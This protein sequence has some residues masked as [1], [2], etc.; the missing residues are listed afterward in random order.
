MKYNKRIVIDASVARASGNKPGTSANCRKILESVRGA[1]HC[2]VF[3][4]PIKTEWKNHQSLNAST[5]RTSMAA[6][7]LICK[8]NPPPT[9]APLRAAIEQRPG[10]DAMLKDCHLLEAALHTDKIVISLDDA[11]R[12]AYAD[13]CHH[14]GEIKE[15]MWAN[16]NEDDTE[17]WLKLRAPDRGTVAKSKKLKHYQP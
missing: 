16:P 11:V 1:S 4:A 2:V 3:T 8:L 6:K 14:Y 17:S 10:S 15:V 9:N 12:K 7:G 13:L 5:W